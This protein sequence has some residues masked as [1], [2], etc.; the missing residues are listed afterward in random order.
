MVMF[1]IDLALLANDII[2]N[3]PEIYKVIIPLWNLIIE[4][5]MQYIGNK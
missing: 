2:V 1:I 4:N 3:N 5:Y